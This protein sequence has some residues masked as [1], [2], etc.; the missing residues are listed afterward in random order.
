MYGSGSEHWPRAIAFST[1]DSSSP[2]VGCLPSERNPDAEVLLRSDVDGQVPLPLA[3]EGVLR[4]V[5]ESRYGTILVEVAGEDVFVNGQRVEPHAAPQRTP[6]SLLQASV[7]TH[8]ERIH[9]PP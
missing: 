4:Y 2:T 5:W 8:G 6:R 3:S 9:P 7:R 1:P